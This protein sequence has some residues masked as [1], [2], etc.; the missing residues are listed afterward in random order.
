M[1]HETQYTPEEQIERIWDNEQVKTVMAKHAYLLSG[2]QRRRELNELWV[3]LPEN[4]RTASLGLNTGFYSGMEEITRYYVVENETLRQQQRQ[5]FAAVDPALAEEPDGLGRG[6]MNIHSANTPVIYVSDDGKTAKYL[7][8]DFGLYTVGKPN[9]DCDAF[10]VSGN[11]YCDL[12]KE[13]GN[14]KI[15]HLVMEH[16]HSIPV[17]QDY[18][19][20]PLYLGPQDDPVA[21]EFGT[22]TIQRTVHN[23]MLGWEHLYQ[24]MPMPYYTYNALHSYGPEGDLGMPYYERERRY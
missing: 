4:R 5:A 21:E 16:D 3:Q 24:D 6:I 1:I 7:A 2:D 20:V 14:W 18:G 11:V 9:G 22:P 17:G 13:N 8:F 10:F 12:I 23:P 15:W 19:N